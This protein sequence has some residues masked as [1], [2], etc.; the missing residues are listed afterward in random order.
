ML[1]GPLSILI[2]VGSNKMKFNAGYANIHT[3]P[4]TRNTLPPTLLQI[5]N[6]IDTRARVSIT[7][8]VYLGILLQ[9]SLSLC[10]CSNPHNVPRG[11]NRSAEQIAV[12]EGRRHGIPKGG[13]LC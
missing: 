1:I 5:N 8:D 4:H 7:T 6:L 11:W 9:D 13:S 10:M 12:V 2:S 3:H